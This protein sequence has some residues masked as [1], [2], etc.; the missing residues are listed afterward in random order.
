MI[1]LPMMSTSVSWRGM[2]N[3]CMPS[4]MPTIPMASW[5]IVN[6][7]GILLW[8]KPLGEAGFVKIGDIAGKGTPQVICRD[9]HSLR[10]WDRNG[11]EVPNVNTPPVAWGCQLCRGWQGEPALISCQGTTIEVHDVSGDRTWHYYIPQG[12]TYISHEVYATPVFLRAHH[13]PY[14]A[15]LVRHEALAKDLSGLYIFDEH[16]VLVY[17]QEFAYRYQVLAAVPS[18]HAGAEDLLVGL[19]TGVMRYSFLKETPITH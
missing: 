8:K 15:V 1:G 12:E 18:D 3:R 13:P 5:I 7:S 2:G 19:T 10:V 16:R 11:S 17:A 14:F 9:G 6:A 4:S